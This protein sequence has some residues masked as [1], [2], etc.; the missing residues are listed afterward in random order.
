M[1]CCSPHGR[2]PQANRDLQKNTEQMLPR[3]AVGAPSLEL[4]KVRL[5]RA[6]SDL[7]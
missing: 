5:D 7:G 4:L 3:E 6:W 2:V 1:V